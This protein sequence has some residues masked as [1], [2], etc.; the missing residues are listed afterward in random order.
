MED[1]TADNTPFFT[2]N[3]PHKIK[4]KV[5]SV[6]DGDTC[7][8]V[9]KHDCGNYYQWK[10]RLFGYNAPEIRPL[11][12]EENRDDIIKNAKEV[13]DFLMELVLGKILFIKCSGNGKYGRVLGELYLNEDDEESVNKVVMDKFNLEF[14]DYK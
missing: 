6:Y 12:K 5:V 8:I 10:V 13:R 2:F 1:C 7:N 4:C 9:L 11:L 14:V 3:S